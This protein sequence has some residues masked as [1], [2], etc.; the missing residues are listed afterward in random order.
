MGAHGCRAEEGGHKASEGWRRA[1]LQP[2][3]A[4]SAPAVASPSGLT[5]CWPGLDRSCAGTPGTSSWDWGRCSTAFASFRDAN[6]PSGV[7]FMLPACVPEHGA[8]QRRLVRGAPFSPSF[9]Q[10]G[11]VGRAPRAVSSP[12]LPSFWPR[13]PELQVESVR[14]LPSRLSPNTRRGVTWGAPRGP[15]P[16]GDDTCAG[17]PRQPSLWDGTQDSVSTAPRARAPGK[18]SVGFVHATCPSWVGG[19]CSTSL[20]SGELVS[21]APLKCLR[22]HGSREEKGGSQQPHRPEGAPATSSHVT[23]QA[24][25]HSHT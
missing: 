19:L 24:W 4:P 14:S 3:P 13:L 12:E 10:P 11:L 18:T 9:H 23:G 8:G 2:Q 16:P 6:T 15:R 21:R 25:L 5:A 7:G 20:F 1:D 22:D 17:E